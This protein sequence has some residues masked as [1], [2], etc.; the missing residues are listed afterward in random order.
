[1]RRWFVLSVAALL[2]TACVPGLAVNDGPSFGSVEIE[3]DPYA[4]YVEYAIDTEPYVGPDGRQIWGLYGRQARQAPN[5][6][7]FVQWWTSYRADRWKFYTR[8]NSLG[9]QALEVRQVDR[10]VV[11]CSGLRP[12]GIHI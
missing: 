6:V 2:L 9:G 11:S 7:F 12:V 3:D 1:M 10:E 5:R 4:I 8:A